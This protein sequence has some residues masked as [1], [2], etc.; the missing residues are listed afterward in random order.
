MVDK[1]LI[2]EARFYNDIIDSLVEGAIHQLDESNFNYERLEVPGALEIP[3]AIALAADTGRF[4]GFIALGCI[5]RGETS[6]YD[7]VCNESARGLM[8]LSIE[9]RLAIGNGIITV[10]NQEQAWERA[11][12]SRKNKGG[13]AALAAIRMHSVKEYYSQ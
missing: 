2:I 11:L 5:I 4:L 10:E 3:T 12:I 1:F 9:K 8:L 6:H 7:T 13:D